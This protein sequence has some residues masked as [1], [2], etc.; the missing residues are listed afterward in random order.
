MIYFT[1][2]FL[3]PRKNIK[4][5]VCHSYEQQWALRKKE[6]NLMLLSFVRQRIAAY[7][8]YN[9]LS[10]ERALYFADLKNDI[11]NLSPLFATK[12]IKALS[13]IID[14]CSYVMPEDNTLFIHWSLRFDIISQFC[15][16]FLRNA[17]QTS[18]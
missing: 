15:Q 3:V 16:K 17:I 2:L 4:P 5:I 9:G 8:A 6:I 13:K 14:K 1:P 10:M 7:K 11:K 12:Y 18:N